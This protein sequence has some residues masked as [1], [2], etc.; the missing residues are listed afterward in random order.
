MDSLRDPTRKAWIID[1]KLI[2]LIFRKHL[3]IKIQILSLTTRD[4][5]FVALGGA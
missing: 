5:D 1:L 3:K 2:D 4:A